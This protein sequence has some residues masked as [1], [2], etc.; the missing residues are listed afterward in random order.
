MSWGFLGSPKGR[1]YFALYAR[2]MVIG[3]IV[4][5]SR[6]RRVSHF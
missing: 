1:V 5:R 6:D 3:R 4:F 2:S